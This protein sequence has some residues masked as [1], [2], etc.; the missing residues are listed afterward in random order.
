MV[1]IRSKNL[2]EAAVS[3]LE[4]HY[5]IVK[6]PP[7]M[8]AVID[9][10]LE[11][12]IEFFSLPESIKQPFASP[13]ILEGYRRL[14]SEKDS[15]T[16]RPDLS[17]SYATWFRNRE[18]P[19]VKIWAEASEFHEI[20][21]SGLDV[22]GEFVDEFLRVLKSKFV[23]NHQNSNENV[24]DIKNLS[25]LQMN[26][27]RPA[28]HLSNDRDTLMDP[29]ED[30]HIVTILKPT[31]PGLRVAI[32]ELV[33]PP[34]K[35]NPVGVFKPV[36]ELVPM[37]IEPDEAILLPSSPTFYMTGG[38][39]KPLFHAVANEGDDIRQSLMFFVNPTRERNLTPW[40]SNELNRGVD[41][42]QVVDAVSGQYGQP[43]ISQSIAPK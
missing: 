11:A 28:Q 6:L 22:Y 13:E 26:F 23:P 40:I 16:G 32:G 8:Q 7:K 15:I 31:K 21:N 18:N 29:H 17:E 33:L 12:G 38:R 34:T 10:I 43:A 2:E 24:M 41:I 4:N 42:H 3:L 14:G 30:G 5:A 39:I 1:F 19:Q 9:R 25:Y 27:S 37:N 36:S 35:D 20:M